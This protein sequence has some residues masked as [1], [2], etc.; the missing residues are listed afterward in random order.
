MLV[1]FGSMLIVLPLLSSDVSKYAIY[2]VSSSLCIFLT[3]G[4]FGFLAAC[5]KYCSEAVGRNSISEESKYLGFSASLLIATFSIF[6]LIMVLVAFNPTVIIP[7]LDE[8]SFDFASKIF[9]ITGLLMPVQV[10]LQ[11]LI[12]LILSSR[13]KDYLFSRVDML[14]NLSK[15]AIVPLF[16]Q[17]TEFLLLEY[18]LVTIL[19][20]IAS[21][22]VGFFIISNRKIFPLREISKNLG[23]SQKVF[24]KLKN[25]ALS[26][27]VSTILW[28]MY[29]EVDLIIAAQ[30]FSIEDVAYYALAFT[31]M[32]FLRSLWVMGFAPF[33]PLMNSY[34]GSGNFSEVKNISS[35]IIIFTI[36]LFIIVSL[37]LGKHMDQIIIYWVGH[38]FVPSISIL[39]SL[40][41]G[42][43][44]V[45]FTNVAAHYMTTFKLYRAIIIFGV[46][47]LLFF[48]GGFYFLMYFSPEAGILNLA[49]AKAL[50]GLA[51]SFMGIYLLFSHKVIDFKIL[52]RVV[53]FSILGLIGLFCMPVFISFD[54]FNQEPNIKALV[55]LLMSVGILIVA[56]F[57]LSMFIFKSSR[58]LLLNIS[59]LFVD[60]VKH[61][62]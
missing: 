4:D 40:L 43:T 10:V 25:L 55:F 8:E 7:E 32:N 16:M 37:L 5:Q 44:L 56:I 19:L 46:V 27:L 6:S 15:I 42:I 33:L 29:Y 45:G 9:L 39:S 21:C 31:F 50:S 49:Y 22:I 17:E 53:F 20:S 54:F 47:P 30:F 60:V 24:D 38:N 41:L 57:I 35:S 11:R 36:P 14:V 48:Y 51:A 59:R 52:I 12:Y 1:G 61:Q 28:V 2:A 58:N 18:F 23:F 26:M 34:F 62:A 3:Y 13:L